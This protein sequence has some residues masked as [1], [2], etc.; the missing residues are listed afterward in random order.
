[1]EFNVKFT[2][3]ITISH[4]DVVVS[5]HTVQIKKGGS[6]YKVSQQSKNKNASEE[7]STQRTAS[8]GLSLCAFQ[9]MPWWEGREAELR[10]AKVMMQ[11]K[12]VMV[13]ASPG[14]YKCVATSERMDEWANKWL[15]IIVVGMLTVLRVSEGRCG[16]DKSDNEKVNTNIKI[17]ID[18]VLNAVSY[19]HLTL[20]TIHLV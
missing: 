16:G 5:H 10:R 8:W 1:M 6:S 13:A 11:N 17:N 2:N 18:G 3:M 4:L 19:T 9:G 12:L 15:L 14:R 7:T 20:P